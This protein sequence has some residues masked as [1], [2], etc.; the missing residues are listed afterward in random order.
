VELSIATI[1]TSVSLTCGVV[2]CG[3][4]GD[5]LICPYI[6]PQHL[7]GDTYANSLQDELPAI[8]VNV[9]LQR[10]RM[11]YQHDGAPPHFS[12][13][14]RQYLNHKFPNRW[15]GRGGIQNWPPRSPDLNPLDYHVRGYMKAVVCAHKLNTREELLQ[16]IPS[17]AVFRKVTRSLVTRV[18]KCIQ[19]DG[20]HF[21]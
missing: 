14:V 7:T 11:Y 16:R 4:I 19:A 9:P 18:R 8:L 2:W 15:I 3:V 20:G 10:R 12:Q 17:A 6:F 13:V 5:Q 1:Y 21:E